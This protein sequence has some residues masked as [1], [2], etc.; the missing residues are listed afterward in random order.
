MSHVTKPAQAVVGGAGRRTGSSTALRGC[1]SAAVLLH[2]E[3]A[4]LQLEN[5]CTEGTINLLRH[6][7]LCSVCYGKSESAA[8]GCPPQQRGG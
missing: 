5:I 8:G 6:A 4:R 2:T 7:A 3:P 1:C